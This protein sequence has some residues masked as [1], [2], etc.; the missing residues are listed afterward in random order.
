M[1]FCSKTRFSNNPIRTCFLKTDSK[2]AIQT[3]TKG[4]SPKTLALP[5][6]EDHIP[7]MLP[8]IRTFHHKIYIPIEGTYEQSR[9]QQR[10]HKAQEH[11]DRIKKL[12]EK[13]QHKG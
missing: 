7:A 11:N 8:T 13:R 12:D 6:M 2:S 9:L 1:I 3:T 5:Q 4:T 10:K